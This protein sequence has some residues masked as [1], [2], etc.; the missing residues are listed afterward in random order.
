M[1]FRAGRVSP[2]PLAPKVDLTPHLSSAIDESADYYSRVVNWGM[3]GNDD[4]GDCTCASDGHIAIQQTAYGLGSAEAVSNADVL[5]VYAAIA[6][7]NPGAGPPGQNPTDRGATVQSALD[8]LRRKG[9]NGFKIAAYGFVEPKNHDAVKHAIEEFGALSV[10]FNL[11]KSALSANG[12]WTVVPGSPI[13]GGHCVMIAGFDADWLYAISWGELVRISWDFWD[14]Y[15]EESWAIISEDWTTVTELSLTSF[16]EEFAE[17]FATANPFLPAEPYS[18]FF[19]E[20]KDWQEDFVADERKA[21]AWF[22]KLHYKG[23]H[24]DS[25]T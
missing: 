16:G 22:R 3:L 9:I 10:G 12:E 25:R 21:F 17:T 15:C 20:L 5:R 19:D 1:E 2:D 13:D 24:R 18:L 11:P 8:Y 23:V 14:T 4:W 6:G 7:F